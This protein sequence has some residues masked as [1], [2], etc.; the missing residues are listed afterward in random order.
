MCDKSAYRPAEKP[1]QP[2][3]QE[4]TRILVSDIIKAT[5]RENRYWRRFRIW[6]GDEICERCGSSNVEQVGYEHNHRHSCNFCG[7]VTV[8]TRS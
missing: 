5:E 6:C 8:V 4:T 1:A 7:Y 3:E 2:I